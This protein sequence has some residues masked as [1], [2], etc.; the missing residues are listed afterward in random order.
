MMCTPYIITKETRSITTS[1]SFY[2][3][4]CNKYFSEDTID[5]YRSFNVFMITKRKYC[6]C[7]LLD[8][9][10]KICQSNNIN[11]SK[12]I[13]DRDYINLNKRKFHQNVRDGLNG[14]V[15]SLR[16]LFMG[17]RHKNLPLIK[18]LLKAF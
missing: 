4:T 10:N 16:T 15:D 2:Y 18:L 9:V 7:T 8:R 17:D 1:L 13:H 14:I 6:P 12:F 3:R 11:M 5:I